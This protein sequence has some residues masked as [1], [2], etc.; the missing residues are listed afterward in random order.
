M[1]ASSTKGIDCHSHFMDLNPFFQDTDFV[2]CNSQN[3]LNCTS[4]RWTTLQYL[5]LSCKSQSIRL[6]YTTLINP[7][8]PHTRNKLIQLKQYTNNAH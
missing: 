4:V 5:F 7:Y 2:P 3:S 8:V 6:I 1:K